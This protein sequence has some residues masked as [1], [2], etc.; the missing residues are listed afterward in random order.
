MALANEQTVA[1][2]G[3]SEATRAVLEVIT[4]VEAALAI[5]GATVGGDH[6]VIGA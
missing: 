4:I 3:I 6:L 5:K 2:L 1:A